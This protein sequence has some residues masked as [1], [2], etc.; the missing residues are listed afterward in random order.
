[1]K[2]MYAVVN[3]AMGHE[4]YC[5]SSLT[6]AAERLDPGTCYGVGDTPAEAR[7]FAIWQAAHFR[8]PSEE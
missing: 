2:R 6:T 1:V 4:V 8:G 5:G 3:I 7:A